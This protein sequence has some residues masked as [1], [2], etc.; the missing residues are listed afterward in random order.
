MRICIVLEGCYP[1]VTGG[2]SS[3]TH[4][5]IKSFPQHEF[6]LW[7]IG[8]DSA[9]RGKYVYEL[10]D[11]VVEI[12]EVFLNDALKGTLGRKRARFTPEQ[13]QA[14]SDFVHCASPDWDVLFATMRQKGM[15]PM[16]FLMSETFLDLMTDICRRD[17]P[18][19]AFSDMFHTLRSMLLPVL[20]L[21]CQEVPKADVYHTIA[22]GYSGVLACL[23]GYVNQA[24]VMLSEHGIYSREREEEIIRATWVLP[25]FKRL[26]VRFFFMLSRAIYDR[27]SVVTS[28]FGNARK[29]QIELGCD[30]S[31]CRITPNGVNVEKFG[32][33]PPKEPDG[34][35]DIGAIVRIA[36]IKD[37]KTLL[38][39]FAEVKHYVNNARLHVIGPEDDKEY[40]QECYELARQLDLHDVLFTGRVDTAQYLSKIDFTVLTSI[41]EGQPLSV[42]ESF[43]AGRPCVL[44]DVGCCRELLDGGEGDDLGWA[45]FCVEPMNRM[46]LASAL[47]RMCADADERRAMGEIGR[48]RVCTYYRQEQM[49]TTYT[50]LYQEV[51]SSW[52]A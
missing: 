14:L 12:H 20:F 47:E 43:A 37:V 13:K 48:K 9:D 2:V 3:W 42:L 4:S 38:Y 32:A 33:V 36:P 18:Y 21:M 6:V 7:C 49:V 35:V 10:P 45:G 50:A 23:G 24:P 15:T 16:G 44:T 34:W 39:A 41:S 19:T 26:W 52:Q 22:A 40:A 29:A 25:A 31:K 30:P 5:L 17:Y 51:V 27:A 1:Y 28:L 8:A 11:N 46:A